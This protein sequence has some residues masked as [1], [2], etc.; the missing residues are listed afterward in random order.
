M[1]LYG[2]IF[3]PFLTAVVRIVATIGLLLV[4]VGR[5]SAA[6]AE[7]ATS[8]S[9]WLG[10]K[11]GGITAAIVDRNGTRFYGEGRFG[12]GDN[13][14]P[15]ET[16]LFEIGSL[17]KP[18]TALLLADAVQRGEV[19]LD[20]PIGT[21]PGIVAPASITFEMV[22]THRSGLPRNPPTMVPANPRDPFADLS[23]DKLFAA[24]AEVSLREP[25]RRS[26]YSNFGFAILGQSLAKAVGRPFEDLLQERILRPLEM[27]STTVGWRLADPALLAPPFAGDEPAKNWT[28]SGY[29]PAGGLVSSTRDLARLLEVALGKRSS[30][31]H[32]A[33]AACFEPRADG[34]QGTRTGLAWVVQEMPDGGTIIWHN[35]ATGGYRSFLGFDRKADIGVVLLANHDTPLEPLAFALLAGKAYR[36]PKVAPPA[37]HLVNYLGKYV[38]ASKLV[39][40]VTAEGT[41][42]FLQPV[43]QTRLPLTKA[44]TDTFT[45]FATNASITFVRGK[46]GSVDGLTLHQKGRADIPYTRQTH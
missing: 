21:I 34:D 46:D 9:E 40:T 22:A 11:P 26:E 17:T 29:A 41:Q 20:Q 16:T 5:L 15:D 30:P 2:R 28:A 31:L 7:P 10:E 25:G 8:L 43:G 32:S 14:R 39:M 19:K 44:G 23:V 33:L 42:L 45:V 18:F 6:D 37:S 35:G 27:E 1:L 38:P 24:L 3:H 36:A 4:A 12:P 13:R